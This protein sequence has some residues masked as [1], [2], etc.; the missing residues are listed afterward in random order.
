MMET[1]RRLAEAAAEAGDKVV[2]TGGAS[3][4]RY[5]VAAAEP[6]L[7][8]YTTL[9]PA[10]LLDISGVEAEETSR[11]ADLEIIQTDDA[12]VFSDA[13]NKDGVP[14]ASPVQTYLELSAGDR[15]QKDAAE[16]VRRGILASLE[17]VGEDERP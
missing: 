11:F 7:S 15:R 12:R 9:S 6:M 14:F 8:V 16:Q 1:A 10:K 3:V 4:A 13:R 17:N 5:A 2:M